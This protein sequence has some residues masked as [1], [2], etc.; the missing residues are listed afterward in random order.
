M[1]ALGRGNR[2]ADG[3]VR[4]ADARTVATVERAHVHS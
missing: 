3:Q 2:K 4:L 1:A